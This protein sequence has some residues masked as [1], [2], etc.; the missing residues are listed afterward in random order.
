[1]YSSAVLD[2]FKN[3]RNTGDLQDATA[4]VEVSNPVCGDVL[5]L[6]AQVKN[7]IVSACRFKAQG[8]VTA[9]ACASILTELLSGK[10]LAEARSISAAQISQALGGLE[11]ATFH[12]A[13]LAADAVAALLAKLPG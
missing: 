8:C 6:S 12:G 9:V 3:P 4:V 11:Q 5:R 2:H 10:S 1:M 7:G 13:Q